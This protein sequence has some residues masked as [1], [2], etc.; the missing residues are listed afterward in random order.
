[1]L[2]RLSMPPH[3]YCMCGEKKKHQK[4]EHI[5]RDVCACMRETFDWKALVEFASIFTSLPH[6]YCIHGEAIYFKNFECCEQCLV[7]PTIKRSSKK[8]E[9]K[10]LGFVMWVIRFK[11]LQ[12]GRPQM[13]MSM[14]TWHRVPKDR[15]FFA[16]VQ[17]RFHTRGWC[18]EGSTCLFFVRNIVRW[19]YFKSLK[20]G[21]WSDANRRPPVW[22]C[23]DCSSQCDVEF[24]DRLCLERIRTS[25]I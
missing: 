22:P 9:G 21:F 11:S 4:Q 2:Y 7:I 3:R 16:W 6:M 8:K 23:G 20:H 1:M 18:Q 19:E 5:I 14:P 12:P 13:S 10:N 25:C 17:H 15:S 24:S